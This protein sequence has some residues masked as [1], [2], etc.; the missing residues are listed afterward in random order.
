VSNRYTSRLQSI[1][2]QIAKLYTIVSLD[3]SEVKACAA[4]TA[5]VACAIYTT[6]LSE[7]LPSSQYSLLS[8]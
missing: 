4:C 1:L 5:C 2:K 6:L 3:H 8:R 7:V